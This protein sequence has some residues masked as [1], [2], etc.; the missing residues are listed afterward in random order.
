MSLNEINSDSTNLAILN[1]PHAVNG[2]NMNILL[3]NEHPKSV[4]IDGKVVF[5][6][7]MVKFTGL[8]I[9]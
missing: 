9:N 8:I 6:C 3:E 5:Q 2:K 4:I 1:Y 7:E